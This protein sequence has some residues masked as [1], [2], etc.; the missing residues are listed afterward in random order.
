MPIHKGRPSDEIIGELIK[1][2]L[3]RRLTSYL[4]LHYGVSKKTHLFSSLVSAVSELIPNCPLSET[5]P[6][7]L[8][9]WSHC[10]YKKYFRINDFAICV[11]TMFL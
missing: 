4:F 9:I 6:C 3:A 2:T 5:N 11:S 7:D 8:L 1:K 10:T